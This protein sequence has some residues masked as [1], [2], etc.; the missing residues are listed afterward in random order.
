MENWQCLLWGT[1]LEGNHKKHVSIIVRFLWQMATAS[2]TV[3]NTLLVF[4]MNYEYITVS[5]HSEPW[6][7]Q[8]S[9]CKTC[10]KKSPQSMHKTQLYQPEFFE[11]TSCWS[12]VLR[13]LWVQ[14]RYYC[15]WPLEVELLIYYSLLM[16]YLRAY[17]NTLYKRD[18]G[19]ILRCYL[20]NS[21]INE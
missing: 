15:P 21:Y 17:T 3:C 9:P 11:R 13:S 6:P 1:Q 5:Q 14:R 7:E 12:F 19:N 20:G 2:L 16:Y 18:M 8:S 4:C 10:E